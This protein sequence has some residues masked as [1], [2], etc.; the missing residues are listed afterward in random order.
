VESV[1]TTYEIFSVN[2]NKTIKAWARRT[3]C[4]DFATAPARLVQEVV[5]LDT[6]AV[7]T[8]H[9]V[10]MW[11]CASV[12]E[13]SQPSTSVVAP[14]APRNAHLC[15]QVRRDSFACIGLVLKQPCNEGKLATTP[16]EGRLPDDS[17]SSRRCYD[18]D[19]LTLRHCLRRAADT[20][21][22][23][24]C[25]C[26][27]QQRPCVVCTKARLHPAAMTYEAK[28]DTIRQ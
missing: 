5:Q 24:M 2:K 25:W 10:T 20:P 21:L 4:E 18:H 23:Q 27:E 15:A 28:H 19:L 8:A 17:L 6:V 1:V 26:C 12:V 11:K 22:F 3:T 13:T 9:A 14:V 7:A 16:A